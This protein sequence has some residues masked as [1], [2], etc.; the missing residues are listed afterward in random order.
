MD[1]RTRDGQQHHAKARDVP[2]ALSNKPRDDFGGHFRLS[3]E[4]EMRASHDLDLH[5][6]FYLFHLFESI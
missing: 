3:Q 2:S 5:A 6:R 4:Q 1:W